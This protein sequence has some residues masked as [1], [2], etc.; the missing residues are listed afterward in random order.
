MFILGCIFSFLITYLMVDST[1]SNQP[2]TLDIDKFKRQVENMMLFGAISETVIFF[3]IM[4]FFRAM[5]VNKYGV[6]DTV[7]DNLSDLDDVSNQDVEI[8]PSE[9]TEL[10]DGKKTP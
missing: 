8:K 2:T 10:D 9:L 6:A 4:F 7:K 3:L 5:Y 1:E